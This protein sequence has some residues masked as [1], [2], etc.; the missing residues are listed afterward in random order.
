MNQGLHLTYDRAS[1]FLFIFLTPKS[2]VVFFVK[3]FYKVSGLN[4]DFLFS[5][6]SLLKI[7]Y[8]KGYHRSAII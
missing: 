1:L 7:L 6:P 5:F 2:V 4:L 8:V 3:G